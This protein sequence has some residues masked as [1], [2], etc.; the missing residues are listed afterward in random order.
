MTPLKDSCLVFLQLG[1]TYGKEDCYAVVKNG[2]S[3]FEC[4]TGPSR[5]AKEAAL[6]EVPVKIVDT[7]GVS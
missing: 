2:N 7:T 1:N 4:A 6:F 3:L 5:I